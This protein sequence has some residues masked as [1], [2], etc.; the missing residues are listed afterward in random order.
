MRQLDKYLKESDMHL[1]IKLH[2]AQDYEG[3]EPVEYEN[4]KIWTHQELNHQNI[5]LYRLLGSSDALIT[6]YSSV[7]FDYLLLNKPIAFTVNDLEMYTNERGFVFDKPE[8]YM[9]GSKIKSIEQFYEFLDKVSNNIDEYKLERHSINE[10]VNYYKDDKN[11]VRI[12][13]QLG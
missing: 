11:C 3:S 9:P 7:Y 13:M 8:D 4:I 6:D 2:P 5:E 1:I 12:L 10:L